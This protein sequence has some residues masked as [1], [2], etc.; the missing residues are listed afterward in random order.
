MGY[1]QYLAV[2]EY[3]W[4]QWVVFGGHAFVAFLF[5]AGAVSTLGG[6]GGL[7][8]AGLQTTLA[9]LVLGLG[10]TVAKMMGNHE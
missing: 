3:D 7:T 9:L 4:T 10:L 8:G 2:D 5:L 1:T 6:S